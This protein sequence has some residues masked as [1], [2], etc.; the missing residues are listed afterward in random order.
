MGHQSTYEFIH[1]NPGIEFRT[2]DYTNNPLNIS[3]QKNMTAINSALE[4]DLT[5]QVTAESLGKTF[6]SGIGGKADFMRGAVMAPGGKTILAIQSTAEWGEISRI[7]PFLREGAGVSLVRGD[8]HYVVT[9]FGIAYLH[10]KN[11]RERAME[12]ISIA[13]PK[14]RPWLIEKAKQANLIYRDQAFIPGKRGEYPEHLESYQRTS[15]GLSIL[16]R[17]VKISDE[18]LLKDFFYGLSDQS[19]YRRFIS[20]RKDMPHERLQEFVIIDYTEEML[21]LASV[22]DAER[23]KVVAVGQYGINEDT[24]AAEVALVVRDDYQ[25]Q[26]IGTR[27]LSYLTYLAKREGLLGFT[28]EVLVENKPMLHLFEKMGFDVQKKSAE[29][30]YELKMAFRGV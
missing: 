15:T 13:N 21:I 28:A 19:M 6:Y 7:V 11:I 26:G 20:V 2:I 8:V 4:I 29:G 16:L 18:P 1:D 17:P 9:E 12:L 23:E 10:G 3:R 22:K 25:S 24:H 27:L 5:G 14:F 30:V